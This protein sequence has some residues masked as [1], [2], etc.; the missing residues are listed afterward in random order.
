MKISTR[1]LFGGNLTKQPAYIDRSHRV[2]GELKN[3]DSVMKDVF[4]VGTYPGLTKEM[5]DYM[6]LGIEEGLAEKSL[7]TG[8]AP[9]K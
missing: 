1:L 2:V 8:I 4:W 6:T 7:L 3:T 5:L 9:A